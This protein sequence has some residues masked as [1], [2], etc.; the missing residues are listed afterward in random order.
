MKTCIVCGEQ[1]VTPIGEAD[2]KILV[3]EIYADFPICEECDEKTPPETIEKI[4]KE[5]KAIELPF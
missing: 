3:I 4:I 1:N 2:V 5:H